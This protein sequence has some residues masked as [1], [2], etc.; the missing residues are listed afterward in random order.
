MLHFQDFCLI[1]WEILRLGGVKKGDTFLR[2][3]I[4]E[5][6]NSYVNK[7]SGNFGLFACNVTGKGCT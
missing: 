4:V 5:D 3:K 6:D 1:I 2:L 7:N